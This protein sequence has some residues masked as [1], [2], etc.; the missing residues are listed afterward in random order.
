MLPAPRPSRHLRQQLERALGRAEVRHVDG[1][2][3]ADDADQRDIRE[4]QSLGDHLR[5]DQ[6]VGVAL[7][8]VAHDAGMR[9][10]FRGG[11]AVHARDARCREHAQH[12]FLDLL[13]ADAERLDLHAAAVRAGRRAR[14]PC[15]RS[16]GTSATRS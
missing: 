7:P 14:G 5:A 12:L 3:R 16:G 8:E 15:S 13:R 4:I 11:V 2:I 6:N 10:L 9:A 1:R